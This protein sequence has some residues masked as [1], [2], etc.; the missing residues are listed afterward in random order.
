MA[1]TNTD[2][3]SALLEQAAALPAAERA[4]YLDNV[5]GGDEDLRTTLASLLL[6]HEAASGYFERIADQIVSPVLAAFANDIASEGPDVGIERGLRLGTGQRFGHYEIE[7]FLGR[8]GMSEVWEAEDLD[9][10]R[11]VALKTLRWKLNDTGDRARFLREGRLAASVNHPNVVYVFGTEEIEGVPIIAMELAGGGTLKDLVAAHGALP[12]ARAVDLILQVIAGLEAASVA[13]VLHRDVKPSN[14]FVDAEGRIQVGDFGIAAPTSVQEEPTLTDTGVVVGTPAFASPE[15]LRGDALDVRSDIYAVGATLYYLLTG[16]PPFDDPR[17]VR[18]IERALNERPA[19][20]RTTRRDVPRLLDR[21][22]RQC[23]AKDPAERPASYARLSKLLLPFGSSVLPP[24]PLGLRTL[25]FVVD[26]LLVRFA[27]G[28]L[29][30]LVLMQWRQHVFTSALEWIV[31]LVAHSLLV[32][33]YFGISEAVWS[34]SPGKML[35]GLRVIRTDGQP[36][37][38]RRSLARA[39]LW[40]L[41]L[42]PALAIWLALWPSELGAEA[43]STGWPVYAAMAALAACEIGV[44]FSSAR[45]RNGFAGLHDLAT[46]TRVVS[47]RAGE[48]THAHRLVEAPP[49]MPPALTRLGPYALLNELATAAV[50]GFD[51]KLARRVW[52]RRAPPGAPALSLAR[53]NV[54]RPTRLRWLTGSRSS[55]EAWD[56]YEAAAGEP[57]R[58]V[59]RPAAWATVRGWLLDLAEEANASCEDGTDLPL[60]IERVWVSDGRAK[61]LDWVPG[62]INSASGRS[63]AIGGGDVRQAQ[64]FLSDV[65]VLGLGLS[66]SGSTGG[67]ETSV[68][69]P[70]HAREFLDD[71][72]SGRFASTRAIVE[73]LKLLATKPV[74]LTRARRAAH[75]AISG[76]APLISI[77]ILVPVLVVLLPLLARSPDAFPLDACLRRLASLERATSAEAARERA[78]IETYVVGR[79][80]PLITESASRRPW[81]WP[82]IE[83]RRSIVQRALAQQP[84]PSDQDVERA[85]Q[86]LDGLLI[87][88]QRDRVLAARRVLG[89][90]LTLAVVLLLI[91][92]SALPALVSAYVTRGGALFGSL[93]IAV[94]GDDGREVSRGR[95]FVRALIAWTPGIAAFVAFVPA[96]TRISLEAIPREQLSFSLLMFGVFV[97]GA[98]LSLVDPRRSLQDRIIRTSLV[99]R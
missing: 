25:A 94:V 64:R 55:N 19:S 54:R 27:G 93:G 77:L 73:R 5:T 35:V 97:A 24:A 34:A 57:L 18:V 44:L 52:I 1:S 89:W 63:G 46:E 15:Q 31:F 80:R 67:A 79:F 47:K 96:A 16:R 78:A 87:A 11:R 17:V 92:V 8:G 88:A 29:P 23:L 36:L 33:A 28:V 32:V 60:A 20:M 30:F 48:P 39:L 83:M 53:R 21:I 68:R 98:M 40:W 84:N 10:G 4:A 50:V 65:A 38:L 2:A 12:S 41:S 75:L 49:V 90:S 99:A 85:A 66:P 95:G 72:A 91:V 22:V 58:N 86:Q 70:L 26:G 74:A 45:R 56:A 42:A 51:E 43:W 3:L 9:T 61:L 7:R 69:L 71:L 81:F 37:S 14:C 13:G 62:G 76:A 59:G 6:A 82:M